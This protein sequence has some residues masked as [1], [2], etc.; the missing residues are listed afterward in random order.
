MGVRGWWAGEGG[1]T[2]RWRD[3]CE[4]DGEIGVRG[5]VGWGRW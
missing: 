1:E 4:E 5:M 2:V 3:W